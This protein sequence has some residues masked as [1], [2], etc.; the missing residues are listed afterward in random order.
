M[1]HQE[2]W[3]WFEME[4]AVLTSY[5]RVCY[6]IFHL[7]VVPA[8][9]T[10]D[11][12]AGEGHHVWDNEEEGVAYSWSF[13]HTMFGLATLYVMMTLTNW[14]TP[15]SDLTT[16]SSNLA[17]VWVKVSISNFYKNMDEKH[18]FTSPI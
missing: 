11:P 8:G 7:Y 15:N 9:A 2:W 6:D 18:C 13:F 3:A 12:E 1:E 17:A 16:L 4:F 5:D 14:F 10:G